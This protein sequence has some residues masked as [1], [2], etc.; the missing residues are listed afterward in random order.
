M[1]N[2]GAGKVMNSV[3]RGNSR[4]DKVPVGQISQQK[5]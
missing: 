3:S 4:R 2:M 1:R 5:L